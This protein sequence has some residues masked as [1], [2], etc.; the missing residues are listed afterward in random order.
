MNEDPLKVDFGTPAVTPEP[1]WSENQAIEALG[2]S[3]RPNPSGALRW[4]IR[5]K[6]LGCVRLGRILRFKPT[7]IHQFVDRNHHAPD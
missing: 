4:L 5:T 1:L 3:D 2:L 6:K 7:D